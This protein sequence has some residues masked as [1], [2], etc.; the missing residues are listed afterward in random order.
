[1]VAQMTELFELEWMGGV[2]EHHYRKARPGVDAFAWDTLDPARYTPQLLAA[3]RQVWT[4]LALSEY[5]AIAAF[6][7][8][9]AALTQARAPLDLI[10]MTSDFLADEVRHVELVSRMLMQLGGA[11]PCA[12]HPASLSPRLAAGLTPLQRANELALRVGCIAEAFASGTVL[13]ILRAVTHPLVRDVYVSILR[14]EAR[15]RRFGSLYFEWAVDRLDDAEC[16]R[17]GWVALAALRGYAP[18][19][20]TASAERDPAAVSGS[21]PG[22]PR[23]H[24]VDLESEGAHELG[25]LE[26]ARYVPVAIGVVRDDILPSLRQIGLQ[27]PE[28]ELAALLVPAGA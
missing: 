25:W 28:A 3:A 5:A 7:D 16:E 6:A 21:Q 4:S 1:M 26:A 14:D 17:L 27:L 13:P 18:L 12:F 24:A 20:R 10:G 8:V 11:T 19:W 23:Q 9:V 22:S 2:A 15:H